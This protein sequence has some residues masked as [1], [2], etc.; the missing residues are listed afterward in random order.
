MTRKLFRPLAS[1]AV[2]GLLLAACGGDDGEE[3]TAEETT[4]TEATTT[5]VAEED[6][7]EAVT[8]VYLAFFEDFKGDPALLED[9]DAFAKEIPEMQQRSKDA[10]G[11]TVEVKKVTALDAAGCDAAGVPSPCAEVFFDLVV[12]G[13]PAVPDQTGYAIQEDGEWKVAKTTFC[14]LASLGSGLPEAC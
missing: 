2:V 9:G 3:T 6:V 13:T 11:I 14:A 5:T 4:T 12:A 8:G 10:G 1:L 7:A